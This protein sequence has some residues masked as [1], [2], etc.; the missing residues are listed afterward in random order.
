[1]A[2]DGAPSFSLVSMVEDVLQQ[3]GNRMGDLDLES[4]RAEEAG[5]SFFYFLYIISFYFVY[6]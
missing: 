5:I 2:A 1:M 6:C 3:H 4:R